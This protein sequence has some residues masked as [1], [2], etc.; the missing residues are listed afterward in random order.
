MNT[1]RHVLVAIDF[2]S[3]SERAVD[4]AVR[5]ARQLGAKI[6]IAHAID[7]LRGSAADALL[8][9]DLLEEERAAA[10]RELGK[11]AA[12]VRALGVPC[13][14]LRLE[15]M[16][17]EQI[18]AAAAKLGVDVVVV[19]THGRCGVSRALLGS[20]AEQVVRTSRIPVLTAPG[21][22]FEDRAQAGREL[23]AELDLLRTSSPV[24]VAISPE[25]V[26]VAAEAAD[27]LRARLDVLLVSTVV[28]D[29][30]VL[31]AI[32]EDGTVALAPGATEAE[33]SSEPRK[34][35]FSEARRAL[36]AQGRELRKVPIRDVDRRTVVVVA[37]ELMD[38]RCAL[39]AIDVL[40]RRGAR[41]IRIAAPVASS[42]A[43]AALRPRVSEVAALRVVDLPVP[44]D[45]IYRT[46]S[47]TSSE[48]LVDRLAEHA[49]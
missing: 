23:G 6:T 45:A 43:I 48:V 1:I 33:M 30:A 7:P 17:A 16:P 35:L 2:D 37:D 28:E 9:P 31:G 49:A 8:V 5:L 10:M 26:L 39:L 36:A 18:V 47:K 42:A 14:A 15:G 34:K 24:L 38:P 12:S 41:E 44:A 22:W 13:A 46:P 29:G 21:S 19:G 20:V 40:E 32:C 25:G 3:S 11:R 27:V 4:A